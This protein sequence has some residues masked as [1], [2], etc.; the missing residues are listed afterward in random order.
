MGDAA[1]SVT[2]KTEIDLFKKGVQRL[3][4]TRN[5]RE[6]FEK[7]LNPSPANPNRQKGVQGYNENER[8]EFNELLQR[9]IQ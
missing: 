8:K 1:E 2:G 3:G 6:V 9:E 5:D 4:N 7:L